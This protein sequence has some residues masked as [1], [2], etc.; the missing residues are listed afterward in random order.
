MR[1]LG[2][3]NKNASKFEE[4]GVE[5]IA[6]FREES[7]GVDGLQKI[8]DKTQVNFTL[9]LDPGAKQ[10]ATYSPAKMEFSGYVVDKSGV[11]QGIINGS[12]RNRAKSDQ[13]LE[14]L[15]SI[16]SG[17]TP[18]TA[19][20]DDRAAVKR[21]VLDYVEAIY[22]VKPELIKRSVHPDLKKLGFWRSEGDEQFKPGSA[23]TFDQLHELAST[24]N[25]D[26]RIPEPA[27]KKIEVFDV[28][29]KIA[30][31][32]LTA[33]WGSDYLHLVKQDGNWKILQIVWQSPPK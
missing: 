13:F 32:K 18:A 1:Q 23:M 6:V 29:D 4:L 15:T 16:D 11:I 31:A 22:E 20:S 21:A 3:L 10:T 19:P 14:I 17:K 30:T 5:V 27:I 26:G 7:K 25:K 8:K 33:D 9:G 2:E 28:M 12:L 24:Y